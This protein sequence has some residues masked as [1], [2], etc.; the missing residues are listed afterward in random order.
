MRA[1]EAMREAYVFESKLSM[2]LRIAQ[3]AQGAGILVDN[4]IF[5]HLI[6]C[7]FIDQRPDYATLTGNIQHFLLLEWCGSA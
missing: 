2:L 5:Q 6:D 7:Q 1:T 3:T 4:G